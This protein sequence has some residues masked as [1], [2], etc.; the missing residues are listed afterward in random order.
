MDFSPA[1]MA[2]KRCAETYPSSSFAG[3]SYKRIIDYNV[4]IRNYSSAIEILERVF[5]DYPDEFCAE[6]SEHR[7]L[8]VRIINERLYTEGAK[9]KFQ[10]LVEE[11][12][13]GNA[14][15]TATKFLKRLGE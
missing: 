15:K 6:I 7:L 11:Y 9:E 8:D 1:I 10:R 4:S 12:P 5:Q 2:F 13:G 14:A 3:E